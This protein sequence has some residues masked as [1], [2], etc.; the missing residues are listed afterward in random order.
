MEV[1]DEIEGSAPESG[2][3]LPEPRREPRQ[4]PAREGRAQL[5]TWKDQ[6]LVD[7]RLR[8][9][10]ARGRGLD[11]P[12]EVRVRVG[13]TQ[14]R[15]RGQGAHHVAHGAESDHEHALGPR[16]SL[17]RVQ[18]ANDGEPRTGGGPPVG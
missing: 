5:V 13:G 6:R 16:R 7:D 3:E 11:E 2:Q 15:D 8:L 18:T 17:Q 12:R 1:D 4:P 14:R 10:H 9:H